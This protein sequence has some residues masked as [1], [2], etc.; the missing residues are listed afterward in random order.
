MNETQLD[1]LTEALLEKETWV[2]DTLPRQ[3]SAKRGPAYFAAE[4]FWL[5]PSRL[6]ALYE[7]FAALLVK[8]GCY[9]DMALCAEGG[10]TLCPAPTELWEQT[11][12][13][14]DK[15]WCNALLPQEEALFTLNSGDLYMTLYHPAEELLETVRQLATAEG[16]FARAG[17]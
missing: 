2:I 4:R 10:W 13:C 16:L 11:V 14:A 7:K 9:Y 6:R 1:A 3:V 15:G 17:E 8:L 12:G 5:E